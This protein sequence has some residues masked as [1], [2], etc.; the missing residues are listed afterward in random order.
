MEVQIS[1]KGDV[2]DLKVISGTQPLLIEAASAA[3]RQWKYQ[4]CV[5]NGKPQR[6]NFTVTVAFKLDKGDETPAGGK[7]GASV[8]GIWPTKGYLTSAFGQRL[9]PLTQA[10][11]FHDGIDIAVKEGAPVIS[12]ADG[13]VAACEN[14]PRY[15]NLLI[16]D[17]GNGYTTWYA[18]LSAFKVKAGDPV[19]QG[20]LIGLVGNT[21][22]STGPHLHYEIR[23]KDK[24]Q[25]P[26]EFM[27]N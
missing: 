14:R 1:E 18:K 5:I 27:G 13:R 17:H 19:K 7:A 11:E 16:I 24:P 2:A 8:P 9:N 21:G 25:N 22:L 3:V 23:L 10:T 26:M 4:P 20:Q 12:A 6:T 15:G